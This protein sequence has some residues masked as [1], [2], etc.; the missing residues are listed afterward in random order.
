MEETIIRKQATD[1]TI[2]KFKDLINKSWHPETDDKSVEVGENAAKI[3]AG[4]FETLKIF[5]CFYV[6]TTHAPFFKSFVVVYAPCRRFQTSR[7][8]ISRSLAHDIPSPIN[9]LKGL[10]TSFQKPPDPPKG[11]NTLLTDRN[12][13]AILLLGGSL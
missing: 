5:V 11:S 6:R 12:I 2:Q 8:M 13:R 9:N 3:I 1:E 7:D 10:R 4:D